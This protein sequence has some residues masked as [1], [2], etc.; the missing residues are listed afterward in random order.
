MDTAGLGRFDPEAR[1]L[2]APQDLFPGLLGRSWILLDE[3]ELGTGR[4]ALPHAHA[5][6]DPFSLGRGGHWAEERLLALS[7]RERSGA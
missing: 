3:N 7:G 6:L 5:R 2:E 4:E 1:V